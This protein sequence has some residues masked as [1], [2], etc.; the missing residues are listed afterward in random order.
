VVIEEFQAA[1]KDR[2]ENKRAWDTP[3]LPHLENIATRSFP[4]LDTFD[5]DQALTDPYKPAVDKAQ[6]RLRKLQNE[7]YR[8]GVPMAICFEGWDA[9]GKGGAIR[10]LT[11]SLDAREFDV[12]PIAAPTALEKSHHHLWRFWT[13]VPEKG[14]IAIF[15]R[16]WYGRVMVER[17]E[18][19]CTES[20]WKRAYDEM[21]RFEE[22]LVSH[23]MILCKFWLQIDSDT[24]LTRFRDRENTPDKQ[25]KITDE[26]WRNREKWP[27]YEEAVNEMLQKT[28]TAFAPWTVVEANNKQFARLKVLETVIHAIE[29]RLDDEKH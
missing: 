1:L 18:G 15:D 17:I 24:Q 25:W 22:E 21:N 29:E 26:D 16:T 8:R 19:Y 11:A 13:T 4:Q 27:R 23:G 10:R 5:P 2:A 12:V 28:N 6:K 3:F 20:Q 9:A 14:H 7:L